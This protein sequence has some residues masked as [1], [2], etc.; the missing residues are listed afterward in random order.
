MTAALEEARL[1]LAHDD[2]P[3]GAVLVKNGEIIARAHNQR[4]Q[5]QDPTAHAEIRALILGGKAVGHWNLSDCILYVTLEPCP[6]CAAALVQAR[7]KE[8]VYATK[9]E[10][11]GAI[12]LAMSILDHKKLNHQVAFRQG[13]LT[14]E[15][16]QILK[17]FFKQKRRE[18]NTSGRK[19]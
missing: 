13:A 15:C 10:K 2:I 1:A 17:D 3:V 5:N 18:K 4:E 8:V 12:S 11:G 7:I 9:D 16:S 19:I 14:E 6:M